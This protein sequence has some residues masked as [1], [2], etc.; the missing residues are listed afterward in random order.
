MI[1]YGAGGG[2][3]VSND[4]YYVQAMF[5]IIGAHVQG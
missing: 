3:L 4:S 1:L 5:Q 2:G